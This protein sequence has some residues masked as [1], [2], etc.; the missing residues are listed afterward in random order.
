LDGLLQN[1]Q[2]SARSR[3]MLQ[4]VCDELVWYQE[5][6]GKTLEPSEIPELVD[7]AE[8]VKGAMAQLMPRSK[9]GWKGVL[10]RCSA[11]CNRISLHHLR[12]R[13]SRFWYAVVKSLDERHDL[14]TL[15][16]PPKTFHSLE[17]RL[18]HAR[19]QATFRDDAQGRFEPGMRVSD[20]FVSMIPEHL[21]WLAQ[22]FLSGGHPMQLVEQPA[23]YGMGNYRSYEDMPERAE[24]DLERQVAAGF[25]QKLLTT[26]RES[27]TPKGGGG[28]CRKGQVQAG[29]G[30]YQV[31]A[32]SVSS[33]NALQVRYAE[34]FAEGAAQG[35]FPGSL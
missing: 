23:K 3:A 16:V 1:W 5:Q 2:K 10:S 14:Q 7:E 29:G 21:S 4:R 35:G 19:G 8:A 30:C 32:E 25:V 27:F 12:F 28:W 6:A 31:G 33:E 17:A 15:R 24:L 13:G 22:D 20:N 11:F 26:T 9:L 18:E 34:G